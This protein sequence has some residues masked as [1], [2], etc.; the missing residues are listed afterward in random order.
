MIILIREFVVTDFRLFALKNKKHINV[1]YI[2][3]R[4]AMFQFFL[5]FYLGILRILDLYYNIGYSQ[6]ILNN[7]WLKII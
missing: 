1:S 4:K 2:G 5:L 6:L 7:F 3:K